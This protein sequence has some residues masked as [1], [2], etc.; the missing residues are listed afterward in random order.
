MTSPDRIQTQ[1]EILYGADRIDAI[2]Q[3]IRDLI[4]TYQHRFPDKFKNRS[5]RNPL[6]EKDVILITYG[7]QFQEYGEYPLDVLFVFLEEYLWEAIYRPHG[8][9]MT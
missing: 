3:Q 2:Y 6:S 1:L 8:K 9:M 7:D 4:T 5:Q